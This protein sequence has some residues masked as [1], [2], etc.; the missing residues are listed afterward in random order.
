MMI[1]KIAARLARIL[2]N[3][4]ALNIVEAK[5]IHLIGH[6]LGA[7][8]AGMCGSSMNTGMIGRITGKTKHFVQSHAID[9][10]VLFYLFF[11]H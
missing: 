2:E 3:I 7:H 1:S 6:S 8:V 10:K 9:Q 4:I 11:P 5:D